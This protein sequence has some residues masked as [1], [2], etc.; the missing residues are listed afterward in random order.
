[1]RRFYHPPVLAIVILLASLITGCGDKLDLP[2]LP[3]PNYSPVADTSYIQISPVWTQAGG[4]PYD[5][6]HDVYVGYDQFIYVCD[7]GNDRVV[8]LDLNGTLIESYQMVHPV[9][10]T[11]D[12]GLDLIAVAGDYMKIA[13]IDDSTSDTTHYGNSL[14]RRRYLG[15]DGFM[16]V[17]T[18]P[19]P[20]AISIKP[21]Q[22]ETVFLE[23]EF[24]GVAASIDPDKEY[25]IA[26]F[27]KNRILRFSADDIPISPP[28]VEAGLGIGLT[29][30][31][32][33]LYTYEIVGRP[34]LAYAQ[35][36]G[37][38]GAQILSLPHG[39]PIY[40]DTAS[41]PELVRM[42]ANARKQ[43]VVD[44]FSNYFVLL[45]KFSPYTGYNRY[46]LK[47]NRYGEQVLEFGTY[48]SGE[49]QFNNPRGLAYKDGILYV[50]DTGND[51]IIRFQLA[52]DI[53]Y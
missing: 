7:T 20:Y 19:S 3:T 15:G 32:W 14:Y 6:P 5:S 9:A 23:A 52:T 53:Q 12:R 2:E 34:Y 8:K 48:G 28:I 18:A 44:E 40:G 16:R 31:P 26:D 36:A 37:N 1:M 35:A 11:Q 49:K 38:Y 10:V 50:A 46:L 25:Y 39:V 24:W 33:D 17:W 21:P 13:T 42:S 30:Y 51:R 29:T 27:A 22:F 45:S 47:F 41:L 4:I 43:I